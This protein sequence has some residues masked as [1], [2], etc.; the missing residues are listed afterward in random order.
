M[1]FY[2]FGAKDNSCSKFRF[3]IKDN[4]ST[5]SN[6]YQTTL[7]Q[8]IDLIDSHKYTDIF[9]VVDFGR[10]RPFP[11]KYVSEND[12]TCNIVPFIVIGEYHFGHDHIWRDDKMAV[13][14]TGFKEEFNKNK[15]AL[16]K[17]LST[18]DSNMFV[19]L[20]SKY[21]D[22][23]DITSI[24]CVADSLSISLFKEKCK[25]RR[26]SFENKHKTDRV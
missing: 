9:F 21:K 25:I 3:K 13:S 18:I 20:T 5:D 26:F 11:F 12:K 10:Y 8:Y 23:N 7:D 1:K 4:L 14:M 24:V 16:E 19:L 6:D 2:I 15:D 22:E 17:F